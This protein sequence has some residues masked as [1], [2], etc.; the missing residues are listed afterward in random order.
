MRKSAIPAYVSL[1][2]ATF[3]KVGDGMPVLLYTIGNERGMTVCVTNCGARIERLLVPD[4]YGR[5]AD[6]VQCDE[7]IEGV[8]AGQP[9]MGA[10][11]G[12]YANGTPNGRLALDGVERT[13]VSTDPA[14]AAPQRASLRHAL[15]PLH[16]FCRRAAVAAVG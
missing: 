14:G 1:D 3:C 13:D 11:T 2:A 16:P 6:V 10:F 7:S 15:L 8:I 12:R 9:S 5:I 4:R